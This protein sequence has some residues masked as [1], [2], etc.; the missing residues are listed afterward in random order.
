MQR[1]RGGAEP[2][3]ETARQGRS[4]MGRRVAGSERTNRSGSPQIMATLP[5]NETA[6]GAETSPLRTTESALVRRPS[7]VNAAD[8]QLVEDDIRFAP[9]S[10]GKQRSLKG[11]LAI[12]G[13]ASMHKASGADRELTELIEEVI[14]AGL[15][16]PRSREMEVARL[17]ADRGQAALDPSARVV[18]ERQLLPILSKPIREQ[19][20]IA[21]I[22]RRGGY[23][24][25]KIQM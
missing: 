15:L 23:V 14:S 25:R 13:K 6:T 20:A 22:I 11:T 12:L 7:P 17:V 2:P 1:D 3:V 18:F 24:P 16:A 9:T 4:T 5:N 19:V 8:A 10:S 21:S